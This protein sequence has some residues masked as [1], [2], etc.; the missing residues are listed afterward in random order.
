ME[1]SFVLGLGKEFFSTALILVL[2]IMVTGIVIGMIVTIFQTVTQLNEATLTFAP[3][4]LASAIILLLLGPWM[5]EKLM[6]FTRQILYNIPI[7][8]K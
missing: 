3:K 1:I 8:I 6:S 7:Y 4:I 5:L 2:P